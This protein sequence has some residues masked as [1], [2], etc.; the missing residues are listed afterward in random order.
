MVVVVVVDA[1]E[2]SVDNKPE[3]LSRGGERKKSFRL[4]RDSNCGSGGYCGPGEEKNFSGVC[5]VTRLCERV[6][7]QA[8]SH[9]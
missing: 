8:L 1:N 5:A 2:I 9:H 6:H 7:S 3:L 4:R